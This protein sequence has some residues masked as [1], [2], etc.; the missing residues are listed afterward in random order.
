MTR[1]RRRSARRLAASTALPA[2]LVLCAWL[3]L[4]A[5]ITSADATS[6][7]DDLLVQAGL[8][9]VFGGGSRAAEGG[10]SDLLVAEADPAAA[11]TYER[12]RFGDAWADVDRNGCDTRNDILERDLADAV[13]RRGSSCVVSRGVLADPYTGTE[14]RFERGQRSDRVQ[15][16][17]IV[18]LA[19]AWRHGASEWTDDE[20]RAFAN[21]PANLLAVD[22]RANQSKR[23][24]GPG[25]WM[26]PNEAAA[27]DYVDRFTRVVIGY[28]LTVDAA[29]ARVIERVEAGCPG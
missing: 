25:E 8:E 5:P 12:E 10:A 15:I 23:D 9:G 20:R 24:Q 16:D 2:G 11:A 29:D 14:I 26:P 6:A 21:D 22:G 3:L 7:I 4:G 27:C 19:Y 13:H 28:R 17:H 1:T 18:P